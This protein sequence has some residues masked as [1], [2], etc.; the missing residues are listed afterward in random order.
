V[1]TN[2]ECIYYDCGKTA[3]REY[4]EFCSNKK[5][6]IGNCEGCDKCVTRIENEALNA[7]SVLKGYCTETACSKCK[8]KDI[9]ECTREVIVGI[10]YEWNA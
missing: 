7:V 5:I 8:I 4:G 2:K 6:S 9:I 10:P 1:G 3:P